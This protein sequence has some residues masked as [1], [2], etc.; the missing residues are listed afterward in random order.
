[1]DAETFVAAFLEDDGFVVLERNW[2]GGGAEL[3]LIV[4]RNG[5]VRFVEVKARQP[6]DLS[7]LESIGPEKQQR[8]RRAAEAWML[9]RND[10]EYAFMV[11]L[12]TFDPAGW[13]LELI[14]DAF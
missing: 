5:A 11:A 4:I 9:H 1:M 6:G 10:A 12:V 8:L 2:R 7:G 3:D 13:Q 14:D